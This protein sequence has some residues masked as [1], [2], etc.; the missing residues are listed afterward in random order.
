MFGRDK[1]NMSNVTMKVEP[2]KGKPQIGSISTIKMK[3]DK[4]RF[5]Q[6]PYQFSK[7]PSSQWC[8]VS[9]NYNLN[10]SIIDNVGKIVTEERTP[11]QAFHRTQSTF[12]I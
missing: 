11:K 3:F 7:I 4:K 2:K 9:I 8:R 5:V 1:G 10:T 12:Y 6:V